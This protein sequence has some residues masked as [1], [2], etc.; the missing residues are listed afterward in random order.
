MV[1][2]KKNLFYK[3]LWTFANYIIGF[4]TFP[5]ITRILGPDQFGAVNFTLNTVDYFLL[6][7]S[8]GVTTIGS[9]EIA[10]CKNSSDNLNKA[11]S[12]I[13]S[14]NLWFTIITVTVYYI[15]IKHI[16][17]FNDISDLMIVGGAKI[18][19][20]V[21]A[22]DWLFTGLENFKYITIRNLAVKIIYIIAV[23]FL[24]K[25][26]NDTLLYLELTIG[27]IA[28]NSII[29][30][31][32]AQNFITISIRDCFSMKYLKSNL[33]MGL[34]TI[35]TSM[36]ITFNVMFL[37]L[38]CNNY[39]VGYYS[40]AV[41]L[42]YIILSLFS[43]YTSVMMPRMTSL[44]G[45]KSNY[46]TSYLNISFHMAIIIAIPIIIETIVLAPQLIYVLSGPGY[47]SAI[48]PMRILMPAILLVW[49]AQVIVFQGLIP[50]KKDNILFQTSIIGG[51][52][53][54]ILNLC[55]THKLGAIGSALVLLLCEIIVTVYYCYI[56]SRRKYFTLPSFKILRRGCISSIPFVLIAIAACMIKNPFV[57]ISVALA[58]SA[59]LSF[60]IAKNEFLRLKSILNI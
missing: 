24:I 1:S 18:I 35:M 6:F 52:A 7:A 9:R 32:Y 55:I 59:A 33:R 15:A 12:R 49:I 19:L 50:L 37:G 60:Y 57:S 11:F 20:T 53:A 29:N 27:S 48:L 31:L 8:M 43:A 14:L 23:F 40:A 39:E 44:I 46:F 4:V 56:V 2:I 58:I 17:K 54:L 3:A 47:E 10:L 16:A 41:K 30:F 22:V 25:D 28:V 21:F 42:Y 36:Y 45:D 34:Y 38:V 13:F 51:V 5:Y 26:R